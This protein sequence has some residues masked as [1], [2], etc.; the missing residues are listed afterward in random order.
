M[1]EFRQN[2]IILK[3][4]LNNYMFEQNKTLE[5]NITDLIQIN[6]DLI[7]C[8]TINQNLINDYIKLKQ[9][10]RRIYEDKKLVEIEKHKHSLIRQQKIKD[11]K[12][13]AEYLVHLNQYIGLV[14]EE[15]NMPIDNL[16]SNVD[17]T[18]T[19]LVNTNRELRQYKNRWFNCALLRKWG[20]VFGL[21]I[22]GIL[23]VYVYKLIK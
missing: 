1:N 22:C 6:D 21:V 10:F 13:D 4:N 16:I 9:K 14:I 12:N 17:S 20:K 2:L 3:N 5:T 7:S 15:A 19:Y 8:S 23:L 18:Q 11:I